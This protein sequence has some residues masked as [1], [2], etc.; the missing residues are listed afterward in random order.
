MNNPS[1]RATVNNPAPIATVNNPAPGATVCV[2]VSNS[3]CING[4]NHA[5]AAYANN[6]RPLPP[7]SILPTRLPTPRASHRSSINYPLIYMYIFSR[8]HLLVMTRVS[9]CL[10]LQC[11]RATVLVL[12]VYW[13]NCNG[14]YSVLAQL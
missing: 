6:S 12:T 14:S 5:S 9:M 4:S 1:P 11:I 2:Y 8:R 7:T 3:I 10:F 13:R